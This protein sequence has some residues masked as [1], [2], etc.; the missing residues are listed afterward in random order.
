MNVSLFAAASSTITV[1]DV[2]KEVR[3]LAM[4]SP[5]TIKGCY[6]FY[7]SE[8]H[9]IMGQAL[10]NLGVSKDS[11]MVC[12]NQGKARVTQTLIRLGVNVTIDEEFWL[13]GLQLQQD[14]GIP[15]GDA[16]RSTDYSNPLIANNKEYR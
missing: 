8:P 15:W 10:T 7:N 3:R 11:I 4:E 13:N 6:Y 9:C 5:S 1:P 12:S 14:Q 16:L 2:I